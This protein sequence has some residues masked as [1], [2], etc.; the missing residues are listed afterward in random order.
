LVRRGIA[1]TL[2]G[3]WFQLYRMQIAGRLDDASPHW[4]AVG[5]S[6]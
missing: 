1:K 4:Q 3:Q 6:T 5:L 2:D